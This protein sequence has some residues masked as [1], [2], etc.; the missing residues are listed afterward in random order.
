MAVRYL[1]EGHQDVLYGCPGEGV[2]VTQVNHFK[3]QLLHVC[4]GRHN[5]LTQNV[6]FM[7]NN[8]TMT[9]L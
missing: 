3:R 9:Q 4:L 7:L 8:Y 6:V 2:S 1:V 5:R